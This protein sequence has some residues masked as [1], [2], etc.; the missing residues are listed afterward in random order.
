MQTKE[1]LVP[2]SAPGE[3][4]L[5]Q[6]QS[7]LSRPL[8]ASMIETKT[9]KGRSIQFIPWHTANR[10]LDKY[11]P[12]WSWEICRMGLSADRIFLVG[13]KVAKLRFGAI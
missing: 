1:K 5:D 11:A 10:I 12:G 3:W 6:I 8:P 2:P 4:S 13:P 7:A 9:L